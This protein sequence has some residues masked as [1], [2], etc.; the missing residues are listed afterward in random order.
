MD[1][2]F[3]LACGDLFATLTGFT[4]PFN[5]PDAMERRATRGDPGGRWPPGKG[6]LR[7]GFA[8]GMAARMRGSL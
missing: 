2:G 8:S 7:L 6:R 1:K 5:M 4:A 3:T